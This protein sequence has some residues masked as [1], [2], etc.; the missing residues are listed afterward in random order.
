MTLPVIEL[1]RNS[2]PDPRGGLPPPASILVSWVF[3]EVFGRP[4]KDFYAP[5]PF[6]VYAERTAYLG[7]LPTLLALGG[8]SWRPTR[9]TGRSSSGSPSSRSPW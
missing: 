9:V 6:S 7:A 3:P 1:F 8:L 2:Q 4:D 5:G